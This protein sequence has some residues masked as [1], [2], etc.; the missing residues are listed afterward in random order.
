M[1]AP[2]PPPPPRQTPAWTRGVH[3]D[4]PGQ[5]HRAT[6]PSPGRPTPGVVQQDKSSGG[7]VDT[8]KTRSG[9]QRVRMSRGERPIGAAKGTHSDTEALCQAPPPPPAPRVSGSR[10]AQ[11]TPR[12]VLCITCSTRPTTIRAAPPPPPRPKGPSWDEIDRWA[13]VGRVHKV[14]GPRPPLLSSLL[15]PPWCSPHSIGSMPTP[16]P[17][18]PLQLQP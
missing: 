15:L 18:P 1:P 7:S 2:P 4:A 10:T 3:P 16:P 14:L 17:P 5:R 13:T 12:A 9:P 8:T 6:A 11:N